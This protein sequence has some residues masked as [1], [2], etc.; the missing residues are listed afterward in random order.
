MSSSPILEDIKTLT[1]YSIWSLPQDE[2]PRERLHRCGA[3]ALSTSELIAII[4]GSGM[5]GRPVLQLA[6]EIVAHFGS[7]QGLSDATVSELCQIKGLGAVKAIQLKAAF[8]LGARLSKQV[9]SPKYRIEHPVHAYNLVKDELATEKREFFVVIL[10]DT[11]GYV[12]AQEVVAIGTLS[13][14]LVHP[15]EVFYP[16]VRHKAASL[17]LVHNHPS[18]DP[19]PSG[20][21]HEVTE[22]LI[23]AGS[24]MSIPVHDHL[25][26]GA[27]SYCS[28]RQRGFRFPG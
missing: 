4:L 13:E 1:P 3:E 7:A 14:T 19:T 9:I 27:S 18:G 12:I 2:R 25:I 16:A 28:M 11:K 21:D 22:Q 15:R 26:I 20:E 8:S 10:L 17:I 23:N 5:K 24:M 6:H